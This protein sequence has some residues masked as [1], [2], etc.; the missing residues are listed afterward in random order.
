M[1]VTQ[2]FSFSDEDYAD[3]IMAGR[4]FG[5]KDFAQTLEFALVLLRWVAEMR[6]QGREIHA[7]GDDDT[8]IMQRFTEYTG[9][10]TIL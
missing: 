1:S 6:S 3:I 4:Q 8:L 2:M 10:E 5:R 9:K 7:V